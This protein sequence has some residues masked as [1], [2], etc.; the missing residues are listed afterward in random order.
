MTLPPQDAVAKAMARAL[1]LA[2]QGPAGGANPQVGCVMLNPDG[3]VVAEGWH[4]GSGTPHA[5]IMALNTLIGKG[6]DPRGLTAV[7]TLEPC[8]HTGKTPPCANAL[9]EAGIAE[10]VYSV[11]DPGVGSGGSALLSKAGI[12]VHGNVQHEAGIALIEHWLHAITSRRPWVTIKWAMSLDGRAAAAD[13]TSQWITSPTTRHQVHLDRSRH[14]A[15]A[16]GTGTLLADDPSLTAR[17]PNG[18]LMAHQPHAVVVGSRNIPEGSRVLN[19]PSGVTHHP[20]HNL[21]ELLDA[22][23][24][25]DITSLYVEGGPTL[26]S[27][28]LSQKLVDEIHISVGPMLLGGPQLAVGDLGITTMA[29]AFHLDIVGLE[30]LESDVVITARPRKKGAS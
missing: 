23:F 16:V 21:G 3:D 13:G 15:I 28:F 29:D 2:L 8:S 6:L 4:E 9:I 14:G 18:T 7:V 20:N 5:E 30:R 25:Q 11:S 17:E 10:V 19:H 12:G 1:E 26:A 27:A 24:N 22:L